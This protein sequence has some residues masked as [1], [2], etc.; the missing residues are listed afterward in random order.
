MRRRLVLTL[1]GLSLLSAC[2]D[3]KK[4]SNANFATAIHQYLMKHGQTCTS[5]GRTF[6]VDIPRADRNNT[7]T[8]GAELAALEAAGLLHSSDTTAVVHGMLDPLRGTTPP[9]PV[10]RYELT[11]EGEQYLR[12]IPGTLGE[13]N[14][15]CYG[16]KDLDAIV[17]WIAPEGTESQAE[18][19]Y[20]YK[21]VDLA[22]WAERPDVQQ[23]F[24]DIGITINGTRK[25]SQVAGV[26]LTNKG[27]QVPED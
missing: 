6:P 27:W 20:T 23:G 18:V 3:S 21:I 16:R 7:S 12:Q 22:A 1:A 5:F 17:K 8:I 15:F 9:Q 25:A 2:N 10:R 24:P 19:T 14:G 26:R 13:T 11:A 4:P